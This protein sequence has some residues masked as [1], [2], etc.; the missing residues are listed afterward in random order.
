M[1]KQQHK[2]KLHLTSSQ[3][4][5]QL[6]HAIPATKTPSI[7]LR[8]QST[9]NSKQCS[10]RRLRNSILHMVEPRLRLAQPTGNRSVDQ[11][12]KL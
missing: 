12:Q 7:P 6:G 10:K 9:N 5:R 8:L 1:A 4:L 3:R 2:Q 11:N